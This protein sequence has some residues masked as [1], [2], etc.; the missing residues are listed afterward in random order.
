MLLVAS[1]VQQQQQQTKTDIKMVVKLHFF[2]CFFCCFSFHAAHT[3][4]H[5]KFNLHT[6]CCC[7][8]W[9]ATSKLFA[10]FE[11]AQNQYS[12]PLLKLPLYCFFFL[13]IIRSKQ[14]ENFQVTLAMF[15]TQRA[16]KKKRQHS[17]SSSSLFWLPHVTP[18]SASQP[19]S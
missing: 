3:H 7:C 9:P 18:I 14:Q 13:A 5:T 10:S 2:S 11:W 6:F 1:L 15:S 19:A 16:A 17:S 4:T 12:A 8:C